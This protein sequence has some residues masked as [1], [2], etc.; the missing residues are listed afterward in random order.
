MLASKSACFDLVQEEM[1]WNHWQMGITGAPN[2][3]VMGGMRSTVIQV[4]HELHLI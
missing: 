2:D 1:P 4:G 3:I